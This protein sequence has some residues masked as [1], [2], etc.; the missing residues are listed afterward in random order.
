MCCELRQLDGSAFAIKHSTIHFA[1]AKSQLQSFARNT[2][3]L[4]VAALTRRFEY[5][6]KRFYLVFLSAQSLFE[7]VFWHIRYNLT[8]QGLW[9][10]GDH[11][12]QKTRPILC[13][14]TFPVWGD[15]IISQRF[16]LRKGNK[17]IRDNYFLFFNC[18][19][20]EPG[21]KAKARAKASSYHSR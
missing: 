14:V 9:T 20:A 6:A 19:L 2:H 3:Q 21:R 5:R 7:I 12:L 8:S 15:R 16:G 1:Q 18:L 4:F 13:S 10:E 17:K 11:S